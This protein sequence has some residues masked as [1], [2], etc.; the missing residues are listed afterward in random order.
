MIDIR[1]NTKYGIMLS[2]GLDSAVLMYLILKEFVLQGHAP[3][4]QPFTIAKSDGASLYVGNIVQ[5]MR[6]AFTIDLP[7]PIIV[8]N[9]TVH[10]SKQGIS[11]VIE[12]RAKHRYI[13]KLF[14]GSNQIPP[15]ELPGTAPKRLVDN[16]GFIIMPFWNFYKTEIINLALQ[17]NI[18]ELFNITHSCTEQQIGRCNQCWQ[19]NERA[20][21]FKELSLL[22]TGTA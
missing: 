17:N 14:F 15:D 6:Q 13:D 12:I 10:H 2:G 4:L 19:C 3:N 22:D 9:P 21:A 20:W 5:Y 1:P 7:D 11:A 8:G 18:Q 16:T